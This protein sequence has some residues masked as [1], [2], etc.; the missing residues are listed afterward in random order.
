MSAS[1][2][3][4]KQI[5]IFAID[6]LAG[7][8][9]L[10]PKEKAF[11]QSLFEG[12]SQREAGTR[13]GIKAGTE[14]SLDVQ[15]SKLLRTAKVQAVMGQAWARSGADV[16]ATLR[17]AAELATQAFAEIK[18]DVSR[19]AKQAAFSRWHKAA[20]LIASIH[21]KLQLKLSG[22]LDHNVVLSAE[23]RAHLLELQQSLAARNGG[24]N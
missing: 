6:D 1:P 15:A 20:T 24:R 4:E 8:A 13:A 11:V 5:E 12:C 3:T 16:S 22:S 7:F 10:R 19:E 2:P 23:D 21:G 17:Q 9:A 14:S 18:G